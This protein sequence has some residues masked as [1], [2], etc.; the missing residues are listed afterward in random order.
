MIIIIFLGAFH[1]FIADKIF[2]VPAEADV[3]PAEY[4]PVI[5]DM[6]RFYL[7]IFLLAFSRCRVQIELSPFPS[8]PGNFSKP[9]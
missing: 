3:N 2:T 4:F 7:F 9:L 8:F 6:S 1:P 5:T